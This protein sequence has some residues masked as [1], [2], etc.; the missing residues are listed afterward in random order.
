MNGKQ[1]VELPVITL[2][3]Y[4]WLLFLLSLLILTSCQSVEPALPD[5]PRTPVPSLT[6]HPTLTPTP[7]HTPTPSP[8]PTPQ[9]TLS[10]LDLVPELLLL[11]T[12]V[13]SDTLGREPST[14]FPFGA[15]AVL[16]NWNVQV[17]EVQRGDAAWQ[18]IQSSD[19][20][21]EPPP[22]GMEY[23]MVKVY[24]EC[25]YEDEAE[26]AINGS[27]F[28]VLGDLSI[29]YPAA[30]VT[31]HEPLDTEL[32]ATWISFGW[33]PFLIGEEASDLRLVVWGDGIS[34]SDETRYLALEP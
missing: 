19:F 7:S 24:V 26:H 14:P 25:T 31:L 28:A 8:T 27:K 18:M 32:F 6:P 30:P 33:V 3:P 21:A 15:N 16:P 10:V 34:K 2:Q 23:L 9:P 4:P 22:P 13:A 12:P 29:P 11:Q 20:S 5:R 1:W 17:L